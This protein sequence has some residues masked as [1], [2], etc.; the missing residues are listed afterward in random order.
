MPRLIIDNT[1]IEIPAGSSV[2]EAARSLGIE[3]PVLCHLDG[4]EPETSCMV[5]LVRNVQ[6]DR[7][8]PSCSARAAEGMVIDTCSDAVITARRQ[9]LELLLGEHVGDCE[10]PCRRACPAFP[11]IPSMIR[12]IAAGEFEEAI[13][14]IK[15]DNPFPA[16][17]GAICP[18]P[19]EKACR[20]AE[21]ARLESNRGN[22]GTGGNGGGEQA[23]AIGLLER[24]VGEAALGRAGIKGKKTPDRQ[25]ERQ[26]PKKQVAIVGAGLTGLSAGFFLCQRG[27]TCTIFEMRNVTGGV[28]RD[29]SPK[30]Y[31]HFLDA[32]TEAIGDLGVQILLNAEIGST[33]T[34]GTQSLEDL[35]ESHD[36][37]VLAVG[38]VGTSDAA[39]LGLGDLNIAT[40]AKGITVEPLTL[41]TSRPGV[42]AGGDAVKP[43]RLAVRAIAAGRVLAGSVDRSIDRRRFDSHIGRIR[44][45]EVEELMGEASGEPRTKVGS[46]AEPDRGYTDTEARSE[47]RRCLNCDC[48]KSTSCTLRLYA[49]DYLADTRPFRGDDRRSVARLPLAFGVVFEQAKCTKCGRCVKI[50]RDLPYG[51]T[52]AGRGYDMEVS[53]PFGKTDLAAP[54]DLE[55]I[56][57]RCVESCPT[58]ALAFAVGQEPS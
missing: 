38:S 31:L 20:R 14:T 11:D 44:A 15:A 35:I 5:C 47:T 2:L 49:D 10:A 30:E 6:D 8:I 22:G 26:R 45:G 27:Y 21:V 7:L 13:R 24:Y 43:T 48:R 33:G 54:P 28:V 25:M 9:A 53:I 57:I 58:A 19:C 52:F 39:A 18:A 56:L 55:A 17:M 23:V 42:F 1:S 3:I 46:E 16:L 29:T 51:F 37:V 34:A 32:E 40:A 4:Y 50:T 41:E 12:H 36:A